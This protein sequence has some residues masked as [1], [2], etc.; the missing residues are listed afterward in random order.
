MS[1]SLAIADLTLKAGVIVLATGETR[2]WHHQCIVYWQQLLSK[3]EN[4]IVCLWQVLQG[5]WNEWTLNIIFV[6]S[7]IWQLACCF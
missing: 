5:K 7:G 6:T 3:C 1:A 4:E 2:V